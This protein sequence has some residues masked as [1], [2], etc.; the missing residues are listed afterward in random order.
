LLSL[1]S[2]VEP[3]APLRPVVYEHVI[4]FPV[5]CHTFATARVGNSGDSERENFSGEVCVPLEM[6]RPCI[7]HQTVLEIALVSEA[8]DDQNSR[9]GDLCGRTALARGERS[10]HIHLRGGDN[11]FPEGL[12]AVKVLFDV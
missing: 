1:G 3:G 9:L 6:V 8:T 2:D 10:E 4:S 7:E 5:N 11:W 12:H